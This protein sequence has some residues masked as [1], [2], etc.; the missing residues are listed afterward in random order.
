MAC[1][2]E[3][4]LFLAFISSLIF[5]SLYFLRSRVSESYQHRLS[6]TTQHDYQIQVALYLDE[7]FQSSLPGFAARKLPDSRPPWPRPGSSGSG[8]QPETRATLDH[9]V[10]RLRQWEWWGEFVCE[11]K[12]GRRAFAELWRRT[13]VMPCNRLWSSRSSRLQWVEQY[14]GSFLGG[15]PDRARCQAARHKAGDGRVLDSPAAWG[16]SRKRGRTPCFYSFGFAVR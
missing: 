15:E 16:G 11:S 3:N 7:S 13:W 4:D 5:A 10:D 2:L 12:L 1:T 14:V 8:R 6:I 9:M